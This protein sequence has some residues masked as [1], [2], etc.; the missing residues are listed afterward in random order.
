VSESSPGRK[1]T[2]PARPIGIDLLTQPT[3]VPTKATYRPG[4]MDYQKCP[5]IV[6]GKEVP[7]HVQDNAE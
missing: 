5:S 2:P 4:A 1:T 3:L 6:H 7:Y